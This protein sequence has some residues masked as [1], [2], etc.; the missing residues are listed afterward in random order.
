[1]KGNKI[2]PIR[3]LSLGMQ[4]NSVKN[5]WWMGRGLLG[6]VKGLRGFE[7]FRAYKIITYTLPSFF[8]GV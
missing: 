2:R 7:T 4:L 6:F 3:V 5:F 1:M 8:S